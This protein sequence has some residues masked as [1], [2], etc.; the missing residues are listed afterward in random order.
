MPRVSP[1]RGGIGVRIATGG[2]IGPPAVNVKSTPRGTIKNPTY[3]APRIPG[4]ITVPK[5]ANRPR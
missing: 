1:I 4:S 2:M 5:G 3:T